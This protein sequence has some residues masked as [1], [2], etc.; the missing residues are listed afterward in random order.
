MEKC[1]K[2]RISDAQNFKKLLT[3]TEKDGIFENLP[4]QWVETLHIQESKLKNPS[5]LTLI[6]YTFEDQTKIRG[7]VRKLTQ[8]DYE[9]T[10]PFDSKQK[11]Y[12]VKID[13]TSSAGIT[14]LPSDWEQKVS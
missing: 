2:V 11:V 9:I 13:T 8:V 10:K 7:Q 3:V 5:D 4:K 1:K 6:D 14:G 12:Q